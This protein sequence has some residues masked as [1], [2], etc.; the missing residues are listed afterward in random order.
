MNAH[1]ILSGQHML[2]NT[3]NALLLLLGILRLGVAPLLS[4]LLG[5]CTIVAL[6]LNSIGS[7][8]LLGGLAITFLLRALLALLHDSPKIAL[9][10]FTPLLQRLQDIVPDLVVQCVQFAGRGRVVWLQRWRMRFVDERIQVQ[11]GGNEIYCWRMQVWCICGQRR[12]RLAGT[13]GSRVG[14]SVGC[15]V[16]QS[17]HGR[18]VSAG[19]TTIAR[20]GLAGAF[21][22]CRCHDWTWEW[23]RD[24]VCKGLSSRKQHPSRGR[25][26]L[27]S[28]MPDTVLLSSSH[29]NARESERMNYESGPWWWD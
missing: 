9:A 6:F 23:I 12:R 26:A 8:L 21:L 29:A 24:V 19:R 15:G 7:L 20:A 3:R 22:G 17:G 2:T 1:S 4:D 5:L 11:V 18:A 25:V 10:G 27:M 14:G 16:C 28:G 13:G